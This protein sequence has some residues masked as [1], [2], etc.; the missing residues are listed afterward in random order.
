MTSDVT[1]ART[2]CKYRSGWLWSH[3]KNAQIMARGFVA[4]GSVQ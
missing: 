3:L 2:Y 1:A 4:A